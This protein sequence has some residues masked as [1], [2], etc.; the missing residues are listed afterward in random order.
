M[1][2]FNS[3]YCRESCLPWVKQVTV[4]LVVLAPGASDIKM[5][6]EKTEEGEAEE[7]GSIEAGGCGEHSGEGGKVEVAAAS[8]GES[9]PLP[10]HG[11]GL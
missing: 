6:L 5:L 2:D 11:I 1:V 4:S 3:T 10:S 8:P 9:M 7:G